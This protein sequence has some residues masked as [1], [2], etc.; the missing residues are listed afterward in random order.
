MKGRMAKLEKRMKRA[1]GRRC[2]KKREKEKS[3]VKRTGKMGREKICMKE[4]KTQSKSQ[5]E[6]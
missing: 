2:R 3:W 5:E 1:E 4:E 6:I